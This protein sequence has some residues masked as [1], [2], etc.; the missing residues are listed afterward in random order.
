ML[1]GVLFFPVT[2]FAA[3]GEVDHAV[4][5]EH[6]RRG[7]AAGPGAVFVACGTGE[8]HALDVGE[9]AEILRTTVA[10]VGGRVPVFAG[11]GGS[12]A[13][14]RGFARVAAEAGV[15]GILLLPPYLVQMP[16]Q[17]LIDYVAAVAGETHLQVI[18]YHRGNARFTEA[19]AATV[20]QLPTVVGLKDG[21][22][23]VDLMSRIVLAVRAALAPA[24]RSCQFF[25]G[26][27]TAEAFQR[28][29][30][31]IGVPLYSSATFA[32]APD[33]ASAFY[34]A[35]EQGDDVVLD[36]LLT[37]FYGPLVRLRDE[38]P[39]YAVSLVKA[40][41]RLE[42][43]PVG[44]VRPPLIDPTPAHVELLAQIIA[45][46]RAVLADSTSGLAVHR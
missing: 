37:E 33:V 15:D 13:H 26:M 36:R 5:A 18:V 2:P 30:L 25:N 38:V 7:V 14:A 8:F 41:V 43:L 1:G 9:Y 3:T 16:Q 22:G 44:S 32:F 28:A 45:A 35:L 46:G 4:L 21:V 11:A 29:Y 40:G 31:A 10:A 34:D 19:S 12:V 6:V 42:G 17:G 23:D 39:G 20:S 24:G 27:P